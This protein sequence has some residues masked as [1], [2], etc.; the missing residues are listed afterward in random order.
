MLKPSPA[1]A[2]K[3]SPTTTP[4]SARPIPRRRPAITIG[5]EAGRT[6]FH[7]GSRGAKQ[8]R[9][10]VLN[11]AQGADCNLGDREQERDRDNRGDSETEPE[12]EDR[13]KRNQRGRIQEPQKRIQRIFHGAESACQSPR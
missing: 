8:S 5:T 1:V 10:D 11:S 7:K 3:S 2:P 6:T 13:I 9:I 4:I 12:H